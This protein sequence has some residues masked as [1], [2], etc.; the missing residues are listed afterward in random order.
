MSVVNLALLLSVLLALACGNGETSPSEPYTE[1]RETMVMEVTVGPQTE[2]CIGEA[3]QTCLVVD[4]ELF[5]DDIEGFEYEEGYRYLIRME[6]Y[7]AWPD[8]DEPPQ[9]ASQYGYRLIE[10]LEKE[11]EH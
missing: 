11:R 5:Y 7:D 10:I 1:P 9:D 2:E 4:G 8:L 6:Q 3:L